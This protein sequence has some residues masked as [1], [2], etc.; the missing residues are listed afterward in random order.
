MRVRI[1]PQGREV[2]GVLSSKRTHLTTEDIQVLLPQIGV[3]TIYRNLDTLE[4]QGL[5][6][7][8]RVGKKGAYYEFI[9]EDHAH[10]QCTICGQIY[11]LPIDATGLFSEVAKVCGYELESCDV[12][13]R[14]TCKN[15]SSN[16]SS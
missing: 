13:C 7:K 10:F 2:L 16:C 3:A 14:G 4:Q 11:D 8:L 15:C 12:L 5:V 6:R 9:R 1:G